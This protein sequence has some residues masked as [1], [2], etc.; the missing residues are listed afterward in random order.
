[1][2]YK[3]FLK[4][5]RPVKW[6]ELGCEPLEEYKERVC[7]LL[8]NWPDGPLQDW[9]YRHHPDAVNHYGW[10][11]FDRMVFQKDSWS[12]VHIYNQ[13]SSNIMDG[14]EGMGANIYSFAER[15]A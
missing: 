8:P 1:M 4:T 7:R 14:I 5:L 6:G 12:N 11:R 3:K 10:L 2:N 9:L 15:P 13:V